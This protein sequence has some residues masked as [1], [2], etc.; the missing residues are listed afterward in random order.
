MNEK[1]QSDYKKLAAHFYKNKMNGEQPTP[2]KISDAL[3]ACAADYRPAY[4]RR[5]R[6]ALAFDQSE[7]G[8]KN[9]AERINKTQNPATKDGSAEAVKPKQ[10]RIKSINLGDEKKLL[11]AFM[12]NDD[13]ES[14]AA[15]RVCKALGVRPA[16]LKQLELLGDCV[17]VKGAKKSHGG[18]RGA[19]RIL[20][21]S[22]EQL[23]FIK[24]AIP[25]LAKAD[26]GRV[27][28]RI[29]G[30]GKRLWP[31]R[32][33]VPTLYT[34][35]HQMGS[36]LKASGLNRVAVAYIMG[37]QSTA[38]VNVYGNKRLGNGGRSL[39][40]AADNADLSQIR[41]L[42]T[43]KPPAHALGQSS[44]QKASASALRASKFVDSGLSL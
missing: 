4:W 11:K 34:W 26:I 13:K 22:D 32:S 9:A 36:D 40:M 25:I 15:V 39:P 37:H 20:E 31:K 17:I 23:R 18:S 30:M 44:E 10:K 3:K 19:D 21:V 14:Y 38:S 5:L 1:T 33:A 12:D 28:D 29:R 24:V 6:N 41:E 27:Q 35:R 2:K 8:Y 43:S 42:H 16:E 7:K